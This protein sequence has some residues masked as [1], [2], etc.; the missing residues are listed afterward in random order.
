[1]VRAADLPKCR[2]RWLSLPCR[3][4]QTVRLAKAATTSSAAHAA[5]ARML[6]QL[7]RLRWH[8]HG[9]VSGLLL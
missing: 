2:A 8:L 3:T 1:M 6:R 5:A 7:L 9:W 4:S